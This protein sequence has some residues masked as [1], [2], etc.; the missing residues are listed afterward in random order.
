MANTAIV[1]M[2]WG[3]EGKGKVTDLL[4]PG[5]EIVARYQGGNNAGHTVFINGKKIVLHLIPS[6]ILHQDKLCLIGNGVVVD[7]QA[8]F[9][10]LEELKSNGIENEKNIMISRCAHLI[11]PY[12]SR[13]EAALE[14]HRDRPIGTT[15]RGIGPAYVDKFGRQGIRAGDIFHHSELKKKIS[16]NVT[17]K[18][19]ILEHY[20]LPQ[21]NENEVFDQFMECAEKLKPYVQDVS[22]VLNREIG[23][24]RTVLL[25]GAQGTLLDIDHGTYPYVTS[26]NSSAG[27]ICSGL[28]IGPDQVNQV[29]GVAK[30]YTTRVGEGPF[31]TE[32]S[33]EKGTYILEKGR[34]FGATTGRPRRCGWLDLVALKYAVRING[35]RHIALTKPDVLDGLPEIK[36]CQAY[37]YKGEK[38]SEFPLETH[39]LEHVKPVYSSVKGWEQPVR[40]LRDFQSL[41]AGFRDYI[42]LIEDFIGAGVTLVSTGAERNDTIILEEMG[43]FMNLKA[44]HAHLEKQPQ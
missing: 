11:L 31:P 25:E 22:L 43:E 40:G 28:G 23:R 20:G 4:T 38:I 2:Q 10:E 14:T 37:D 27:G 16:R 5:F 44:V 19:V 41:P 9:Q 32:I 18:N 34:E 26:S 35:V 12:H 29:L 33:G 21:I 39:V 7:P 1:G 42:A 13:I 17:E 6:G 8:F 15:C 36:I 24:G 30:A 3:D